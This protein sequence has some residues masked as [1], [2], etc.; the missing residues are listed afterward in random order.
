MS[1][2]LPKS[3]H[4]AA[5]LKPSVSTAGMMLSFFACSL[6]LIFVACDSSGQS[7][8]A[9]S[10]AFWRTPNSVE[11]DL[12]KQTSSATAS[13]ESRS[14]QSS[15]V[16]SIRLAKST[17]PTS[18]SKDVAFRNLFHELG[19]FCEVSPVD[20]I[21]GE[22]S[23][24]FLSSGPVSDDDIASQIADVIRRFEARDESVSQEF[25]IV[26]WASV[27]RSPALVQS[28]EHASELK[29]ITQQKLSESPEFTITNERLTCRGQLW[30]SQ[31]AVRPEA[32]L[33]IL[34]KQ[35]E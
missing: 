29:R 32:T 24:H 17:P 31:S 12:T 30:P 10:N 20:R 19:R 7:L 16:K 26:C 1:T 8:A 5:T 3:T 4:S 9:V 23:I 13:S 11:S 2:R 6:A 27:P 35:A 14:P 15:A 28:A 22:L 21:S 25:Q 34:S 18:G 33:V